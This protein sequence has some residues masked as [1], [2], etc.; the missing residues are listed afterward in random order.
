MAVTAATSPADLATVPHSPFSGRISSAASRSPWTHASCSSPLSASWRCRLCGGF[1]RTSF[2]SMRPAATI[3]TTATAA[4]QR[5]YESK[6]KPDGSN[7][8][9]ED[10]TGIGDTRIQTRLRAVAGTRP[11]RRSRRAAPHAPV[12]R[13]PRPQSIPVLH[14]FARWHC[15]GSQKSRGGLPV[16]LRACPHRTVRHPAAPG[17]RRSSHPASALRRDSTCSS[18]CSRTWE[19]RRSAAGSSPGSRR[20]SSRTRDRS[21]SC[22]QCGSSASR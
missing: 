3:P 4:I 19:L 15:G 22:R 20:F 1:S 6:K 9:E 10:Y 12:V 7:Y 16:R 2:Y 18:S 8:K 21:P 13:V 17:G 11:A 5:E 14:Q